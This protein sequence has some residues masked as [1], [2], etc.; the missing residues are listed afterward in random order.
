MR[1]LQNRSIASFRPGLL[2][3]VTQ[4]INLATKAQRRKEMYLDLR[5]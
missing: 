1:S 2:T 3:G 5:F 4:I